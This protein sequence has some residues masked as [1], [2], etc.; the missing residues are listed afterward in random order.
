MIEFVSEA[1]TKWQVERLSTLILKMR[2]WLKRANGPDPAL[3]KQ[4][5]GLAE[6]HFHDAVD[7][8]KY[9]KYQQAF[10]SCQKGFVQV[11]MAQLLTTYGS[12][13]DSALT[14]VTLLE[15]NKR[16]PEEQELVTYL[17]SALAEMK[18][19]IEYSNFKV[20]TRG[21]GLLNSGMDFYNDA[22]SALKSSNTEDAKRRARA[23][24]LQLNLAA[25]IISAENEMSLPG[26]RGLSNPVLGTPLRRVDELFDQIVECRTALSKLPENKSGAARTQ[27][28]TG[29]REYNAAIHSLANGSD[30]HA[31]ALLRSAMHAMDEALTMANE[32]ASAIE[33]N[34]DVAEDRAKRERLTDVGAAVN[35]VAEL[36]ESLSIK[37][38]DVATKRLQTLH[39][40]YRDGL[41]AMK[42]KRFAEAEQHASSALMELDLLR[43]LLLTQLQKTDSHKKDKE[44]HRD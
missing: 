38:H 13:I 6:E 37:K 14:R 26:W 42:K 39:Q 34:E 24:L 18:M 16:Q 23:G 21:Q 30:A 20:S 7:S 15:R 29:L 35:N 33:E 25:Q 32:V 19:S 40:H 10:F 17:A 28:E 4:H 44:R 27:Y 9:N 2:G 5:V 11:G 8:L 1:V 22:M 36:I 31:Q 43:H 41:R 3:I 12:Q